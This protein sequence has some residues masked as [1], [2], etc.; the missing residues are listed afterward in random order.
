MFCFGLASLTNAGNKNPP[1]ARGVT[2][3]AQRE[4]HTIRET[5]ALHEVETSLS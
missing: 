1:K 2:L 4:K 5:N 3:Q